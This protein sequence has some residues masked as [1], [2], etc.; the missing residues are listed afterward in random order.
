MK[1]LIIYKNSK[2]WHFIIPAYKRIYAP[3]PL[4]HCFW[5]SLMGIWYKITVVF[6]LNL[7]LYAWQFPPTWHTVPTCPTLTGPIRLTPSSHPPDS[8]SS[9]LPDTQFPPAWKSQFPLTWHSQFPPTWHSSH[10][11]DTHSSHPPDSHSSQPPEIN[12]FYTEVLSVSWIL[13][14]RMQCCNRWWSEVM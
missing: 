1:L 7:C 3:P 8:H 11:P 2:L 9:Y 12:P 13:M 5:Q 6:G 14:E 4:K 10:S